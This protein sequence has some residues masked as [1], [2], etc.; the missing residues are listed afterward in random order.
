LLRPHDKKQLLIGAGIFALA[1]VVRLVYLWE[2]SS[3]PSF[4]APVLDA[5]TYD[6]LARSLAA[7]KR[8]SGELFWQPVFYPY[9][10]SIVY[11]FS[12]G[13]IIFGKI[14]QIFLGSLTCLLTYYLGKRVFNQT[15]GIIAGLVTALYGPLIFFDGELLA[16][17]WA[18]LWAVSL[19]LLF[20]TGP[21][22]RSAWFFFVLGVCGGLSIITRPTFVPFFIAGL[23]WLTIRFYCGS[24]SVREVLIRLAVV[25][26][27]LLFIAV[28]VGLK[29]IRLTG[30]FGILPS[31]GG[32]NLYIGN[33]PN[34][35]Q[36]M[37]AR[38]GWPWQEIVDLPERNGVSGNR[39]AQQEFFLQNVKSY[40][41]AEPVSFVKGLI[42]KTSQFLSSREMPRNVD[43]YLF[44]KWSRLLS[45]LT[46]KVG[47]F[48]FPFGL[49]LPLTAFGLVWYWTRLPA[50][51]LLF[52]IFYP[53]SVIL[54]FP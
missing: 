43:V 20:L 39:W 11:W 16:T 38:P 24:R 12:N 47:P 1:L 37:A 9:F 45:V 15:A 44:G 23:I 32:L 13:S 2:S 40:I 27:G 4:A 18:S 42:Y 33:N 28:P 14:V 6:G 22:R 29:N 10:L 8:V 19:I 34:Y 3:G 26:L 51:L 25:L 49:L 30:H 21:S 50:P 17:G 5:G 31:S 52:L 41:V 7:G 53:L 35:T 46:F 54:V 36:T 48:G